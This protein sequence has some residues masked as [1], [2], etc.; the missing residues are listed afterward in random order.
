MNDQSNDHNQI[1]LH[2]SEAD[3]IFVFGPACIVEELIKIN[4]TTAHSVLLS[5]SQD[6]NFTSKNNFKNAVPLN[7]LMT[8]QGVALDYYYEIEQ[9]PPITII[10]NS[11]ARL[12]SREAFML[13]MKCTS[14]SKHLVP[15][16]SWSQELGPAPQRVKPIYASESI[17]GRF[18]S[19]DW[20]LENMLSG[21]LG[22]IQ[23]SE[24]SK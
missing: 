18:D 24:R 4:P 21:F 6:I 20:A 22:G 7:R 12:I 19:E 9:V 5:E 16:L 15:F 8:P 13:F 3:H 14:D 2:S 1:K 10:S 11:A 23:K 17:Y